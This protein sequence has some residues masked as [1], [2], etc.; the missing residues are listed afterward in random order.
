MTNFDFGFSTDIFLCPW[1]GA[2]FWEVKI[3]ANIWYTVPI[4]SH[5]AE[6]F[7]RLLVS[8]CN[9]RLFS[10]IISSR[11]LICCYLWL[12][13]RYPPLHLFYRWYSSTHWDWNWKENALISVQGKKWVLGNYHGYLKTC[14][15]LCGLRVNVQNI[16]L[17][18]SPITWTICTSGTVPKIGSTSPGTRK[19]MYISRSVA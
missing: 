8:L 10:K 15:V 16:Q 2:H 11:F 12:S 14:N 1:F 7:P 19:R 17:L 3:E 13:V 9:S 4:L 18:A 6:H 5:I